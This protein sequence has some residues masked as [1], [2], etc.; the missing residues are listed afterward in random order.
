MYII[1]REKLDLYIKTFEYRKSIATRLED[2]VWLKKQ[3]DVLWF[4]ELVEHKEITDLEK[5]KE[6]RTS[7]ILEQK[8]LT[9][10]TSTAEKISE[11]F[12]FCLGSGLIEET[13]DRI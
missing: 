12:M 7:K 10:L 11:L 3:K 1:N 4:I 8:G 13:D 6:I 5:L 2:F 9:H